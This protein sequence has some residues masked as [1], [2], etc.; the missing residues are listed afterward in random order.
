MC[1]VVL[2]SSIIVLVSFLCLFLL[3]SLQSFRLAVLLLC[4]PIVLRL[5]FLSAPYTLSFSLSLSPKSLL[6]TEVLFPP[7]LSVS[8]PSLHFHHYPMHRR[9]SSHLVSSL[10]HHPFTCPS[11][12]RNV[13]LEVSN[14][15]SNVPP[16][17]CSKFAQVSRRKMSHVCRCLS[18]LWSPSRL[19]PTALAVF[20]FH[21]LSI[22]S[23]HWNNEKT[24]S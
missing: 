1:L 20:T 9:F 14:C 5:H 8:S 16:S 18:R 17:L 19:V 22:H 10:K 13:L 15:R 7:V 23:S 12:H 2:S 24:P 4:R 11:L 3:E 6:T 21:K